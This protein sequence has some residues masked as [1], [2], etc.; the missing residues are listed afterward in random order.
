MHPSWF[1][2]CFW[3]MML[4]CFYEGIHR[5]PCNKQINSNSLEYYIKNN[6]IDTS[7]HSM[8]TLLISLITVSSYFSPTGSTS[9]AMG[10]ISLVYLNYLSSKNNTTFRKNLFKEQ[11]TDK[12]IFHSQKIKKKERRYFLLSSLHLPVFF[13]NAYTLYPPRIQH[14]ILC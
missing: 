5:A 4:S 10:S 11:K 8:K 3:L 1:H 14:I 6:P 7:I 13:F 2:N 9:P 12:N